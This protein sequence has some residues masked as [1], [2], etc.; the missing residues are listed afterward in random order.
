[1]IVPDY[2]LYYFFCLHI[3]TIVWLSEIGDACNLNLYL[4][5]PFDVNVTIHV[6][7]QGQMITCSKHIQC[8]ASG[9]TIQASISKALR[10]CCNNNSPSDIL[11]YM[12]FIRRFS[13]NPISIDRN[14]FD[15]NIHW[16]DCILNSRIDYSKR[17]WK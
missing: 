12:D 2:S 13:I 15:L 3:Y 5:Q 8:A 14:M 10:C 6:L 17:K 1:M 11:I 16:I 9:F 7:K 4:H